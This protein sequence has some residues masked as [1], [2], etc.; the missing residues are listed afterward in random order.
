MHRAHPKISPENRP[1][2]DALS[3]PAAF[4]HAVTGIDVIETHISW[5]ILTDEYAYKIKK[6]VVLD[7]LDFGDLER[8]KF[9]CEEEIRLNRPWAPEI[10]LDVV[11][12]T[13]Q[14]GV[15]RFGGPGTPVEYAVRMR[16]FDEQKRLDRELERGELTAADMRELGRVIAERHATA[17]IAGPSGREH[18]V[19][20]AQSLIRDNFTALEDAVDV[21]SLGPL[22]EWTEQA[23]KGAGER[24]RQRF[25]AGFVRDCHGDLHLANLVRLPGGIATFDCIEFNDDLRRIDVICDIAFLVMDL[26]ANGRL[27]LAAHFLNRYLERTGD[28]GGVAMLDLYF[29]Y[30]CL[31]RAK[32]A[33]ILASECD[34]STERAAHLDE[35]H[36]YCDIATR[37]IAKPE[38]VLILMHGLSGSGK[39]R[40]SE[41]LMASLPAIRIR[42]DIER[43][44]LH[45]LEETAQSG[46]P[47]GKGIYSPESNREAYATMF[48]AARRILDARHNVI[49]DAAF[50][51]QGLRKRA[52]D[53]AAVSGRS[54]LIVDVQAPLEVLRDRVR[55]RAA[56]SSDASEAGL[57]VL[58][59][60][61]TTAHALKESERTR[62]IVFENRDTD[63]RV[64]VAAVLDAIRD[65]RYTV[66][67]GTPE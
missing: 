14:D 22:R 35:A 29:V 18:F 13:E 37:Q 20:V 3:Q 67:A 42:S 38:P 8:R 55:R 25:D 33:V 4:E 24:F 47:V 7:F 59:H 52:F 60:Q 9:Y 10:Y 57:D 2:I 39:T 62:T 50:L 58:E 49:L 19:A 45:G 27:Q 21:R 11:A 30:R 51:D 36:R 5:V 16:R 15:S 63:D 23:L 17:E 43:K 65:Y 1:L 12:I 66:E 44:R 31:V 56:S 61:V 34:D 46:S 64:D 28:Y 41:Q 40:V 32:V 48:D 6:P 54:A 26:V 53:V